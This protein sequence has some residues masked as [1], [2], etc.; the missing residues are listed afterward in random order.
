MLRAPDFLMQKIDPPKTMEYYNVCV[1][2]VTLSEYDWNILFVRSSLSARVSDKKTKKTIRKI[3][4]LWSINS[5]E[6]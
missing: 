6:N 2:F 1:F 3:H 5:Q 4:T